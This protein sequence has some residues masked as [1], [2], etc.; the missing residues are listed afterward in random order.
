MTASVSRRTL[1]RVA[2]ACCLTHPAGVLAAD[3]QPAPAGPPAAESA[4]AAPVVEE[5]V[6]T[7]SRLRQ[8]NLTST[9]PIQVVSSQEIQQTGTIDISTLINT[10]PQQ[11]QNSVADFSNTTNPLTSAGGLSTADLR[12]LGPQRTLVLVDGRRLGVGDAST[13]NPNPAPDLD[14]IPVPLIE[15]IDVVTGG[16][17]A[18]YGSDAIAGVVNFVLKHNFQGLQIDGQYGIDNHDNHNT[19]MQGLETA[20]GFDAPT[21]SHWDGQTRELS[22]LAGTNF[23][24]DKGNVTAYF[25]YLDSDPV[26]Q[27]A[28]DFSNCLLHV[29]TSTNPNIIDTPFCDGSVNSNLFA[30]SFNPSPTAAYSVVGNQLL[31]FPQAGSVPPPFFNSSPYQYLSR[32]DTRYTAGFMAN[33]EISEYAKPYAEFNYMNDRSQTQI[34]PGALFYLSNPFNPSG[35]GGLLVNCSPVN[36]LLSAQENAVL[37]GNTAN[38][39]NGVPTA[40]VDVGI[41]R[42]DIEGPAR[43]SYYEHNNWR[44]VFGIKGGLGD[45]WSYDAYASD[46]YTSLFQNNTGY[47]SFTRAQNALLVVTSP[48]TGQPMCE[49]GQAGCVPYNI[50]TQGAVTPAQLAY[51][52]TNGSNYGTVNERILDGSIVGDLAKYGVKLPTANDGVG[53]VLGGEHRNESLAYAPDQ[54]ELS[55]DLAGFSGAGVAVSGAYNVT[56]GFLEAR[57]PLVQSKP[58]AEDL[59]FHTAYRRSDYSTSAG[60]VNTYALDLQWAPTQDF[61]LRGSFQRAIRAPNIIELFTP[62]SVTNTSLVSAD[63]CAGA[64]PAASLAECEHTGVTPAQYG[65]IRQCPA[66]QCSTLTGGNPQ[67]QPE[68]ANTLSYGVTFTPTFLTGLSASVDFY[69]IILKEVISAVPLTTTLQQCLTTGDPTFCSNI[70]RT[71]IGTLFGTTVQN[72]GWIRGTG[73]NVAVATVEGIDVQAVYKWS[74]PPRWGTMSATLNGAWLDH[75]DTQPT[76]ATAR[77]DCA[78]LYGPTCLTVNPRWRHNLRIDWETPL[79]VL[80]S[81]QW[82]FIGNVSLDHNTQNPALIDNSAPFGPGV[83]DVTFDRRLASVSY[84]DLSAIW[85]INHMFTVR[86]GCNNVLDRDPPLVAAQLSQTGSPNTY[87]TY[88]LLGRQMYAAFTATF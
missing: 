63:P 69:N 43:S 11:F 75:A 39:P 5:V 45:A 53:V 8:P 10:L 76:P 70:V 68:V 31:P 18:V 35:T 52:L 60:G 81:A 73:V 1:L 50:W 42:R 62:E 19:L 12:G 38:F 67:L 85:K 14:Q 16:A 65:T 78:G 21:G 34:G 17:S 57:V 15:R 30:P 41:G 74:L 4:Q 64:T 66:G 3:Q 54:A 86:A 28:R 51:L 9:S 72:G 32:G 47:L 79:H 29:A 87:P 49:G 20:A 25:V 40:T 82:R 6:I 22:I 58:F 83:T 44:G 61:R 84:L 56:E 37:C 13:L 88:D 80:F 77:Y 7:G 46:Y 71:P 33:Y 27:G 48:T 36:P 2:V 59:V 26:S 24:G 23:A 55:N